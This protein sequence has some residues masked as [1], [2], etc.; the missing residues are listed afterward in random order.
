MDFQTGFGQA[1]AEH[2]YPGATPAAP[3]PPATPAGGLPIGAPAL[4]L[5]LSPV[6][7]IV[8]GDVLITSTFTNAV[9]QRR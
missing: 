5:N 8:A 3:T 7:I 6:I 1:S 4:G 9:V 2:A